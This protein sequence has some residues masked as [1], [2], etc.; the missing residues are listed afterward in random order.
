M[1]AT[2]HNH[3]L[4][5][6]IFG[7]AGSLEWKHED[8]HHL[9]LQNL[10][11]ATTLLTQGLST[12]SDDAARLTRVGLGHP[13]GFLE[14]FANFYRDLADELTARRDRTASTIRELSFPTGIDGL[15]GVQFVEAVAASHANNAAWTVPASVTSQEA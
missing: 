8:P 4:R 5:I 3:G 1:A 13:E 11:G 6:R 9:S 14:A 15:I 10:D 7:D 2:G 12:L